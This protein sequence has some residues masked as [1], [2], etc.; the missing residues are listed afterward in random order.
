M[1]I[2]GPSTPSF[3]GTAN[4]VTR[5][6]GMRL[7]CHPFLVVLIERSHD[8]DQELRGM[9]SCLGQ[10][11]GFSD[12]KVSLGLTVFRSLRAMVS[13]TNIMRIVMLKKIITKVRRIVY[14]EQP[15]VFILVKPK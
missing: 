9:Y 5:V 10:I 13:H 4:F 11:G 6:F 15:N 2:P 1:G 3:S 12:S 7:F 8:H 14:P